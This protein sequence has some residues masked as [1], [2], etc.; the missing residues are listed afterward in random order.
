MY[1]GHIFRDNVIWGIFEYPKPNFRD[2]TS[3][4]NTE[5]KQATMR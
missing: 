5:T 2:C 3:N 1:P 4:C